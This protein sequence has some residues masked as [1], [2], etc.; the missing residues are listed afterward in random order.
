MSDAAGEQ[1]ER[2]ELVG[3]RPL[4]LCLQRVADVPEGDDHPDGVSSGIAERRRAFF[5]WTFGQ[6]PRGEQRAA[7]HTGA[8]ALGGDDHSE[9]HGWR[10]SRSNV[11]KTFSSG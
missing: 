9:V 6:V 11:R 10:V 7:R 5:D 3:A 1:S 4:L 8:V 2:C